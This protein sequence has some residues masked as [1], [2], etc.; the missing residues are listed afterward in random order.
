[1]KD[2]SKVLL[3]V[4]D[5]KKC[6]ELSDILKDDFLLATATDAVSGIRAIGAS[7]EKVELIIVDLSGVPNGNNDFV[8]RCMDCRTL[9]KI[10]IIVSFDFDAS[11]EMV[12]SA[13]NSGAWDVIRRPYSGELIRFRVNNIIAAN[14]MSVYR[15]IK[16]R[17]NYDTMTGVYNRTKFF[18]ET[19]KVIDS[20]PDMTFAFIRFDIHKFQLIN[21]FYGVAEG[22]KLIKF[23]ADD[24]GKDMAG[25]QHEYGKDG[26]RV[27]CYGHIEVDVFCCCVPFESREKIL[28]YFKSV[29]TR[30]ENYGL[31]FVILPVFGV[32]IIEDRSLTINEMYDRAN[33]ASKKC[34]GNY[35]ENYAFYDDEMGRTIVDEQMIVNEMS[36]ALEK[37]QFALYLQPK[38]EIKHNTLVGAEVLVRWIHP[39][40]GMISPGV[41]IPIFERNGFI[42]QLDN[43]VWEHT[44]MMLRRWLDE[45]KK[46]D[47]VSVNM[48]RISL[49]NPKLVEIICNL[50]KK[51]DV[52]PALMQLELTESA[53]TANPVVIKETMKSLQEHG[54][55]VLMDDF[56]SGYSSLNALKD[57]SLDVIKMDMRFL[58]KTEYPER[59]KCIMA[60]VVRMA[61]WLKMSV[62]AEGVETKDQLDF[63]KSIGCEYIQ[64]FYFAKPMSVEDYE[65]CA[66][67]QLPH[68]NDNVI[69]NKISDANT[70]YAYNE[71]MD[72]LF[73]NIFQPVAVYEYC[74]GNIEVIRVNS[75]Y[76]ESFGYN[77]L[78]VTVT[79][80]WFNNTVA[81]E[82]RGTIVSAFERTANTRDSASCEYLR[83][84]ED[85]TA[86][87]VHVD[88]KY[89]G[90]VE[91]RHII[92]A[93][94][95]DITVQKKIYA[96]LLEYRNL[97]FPEDKANKFILIVED[98]EVNRKILS[99]LFADKYTVYEAAD[100]KEALSVMRNKKIDLILL[101]VEMPVMN[102]VEFLKFKQEDERYN[103]IPVIVISSDGQSKQQRELMEMGCSDYIVKPFVPEVVMARVANVFTSSKAD[104]MRRDKLTGLYDR[105][106]AG[107][108][109]QTMLGGNN[110]SRALLLVD[111]DNFEQINRE[112][113]RIAGDKAIKEF[114]G[115]LNKYFRKC[116]IVARYDGD[117]FV[118]FVSNIPTKAE[119]V[120]RCE[121]LIK[122]L[123]VVT[124]DGVKLECSIGI[125]YSNVNT[126]FSE[127]MEKADRALYIAK[128]RGK[129]QCILYD[130]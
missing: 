17:E 128:N 79:D 117:E 68:Y 101:D 11:D 122:T 112:Y 54:F 50:V 53:F 46:P 78:N 83:C 64:G 114:A 26:K 40:K 45:G 121:N 90:S 127:M 124:E 27:T 91:D 47:P 84:F 100:G 13:I 59:S 74:R 70:I 18:S 75:A 6:N 113:G 97:V 119:I 10:P 126:T 49:Y 9:H 104:V 106:T 43:Y 118:V 93:I 105:N 94:L 30:L 8:A 15:E 34:K 55:T 80:G 61:K 33:M 107:G 82:F 42:M 57:M 44:C 28:G 102:G 81:E 96:E 14:E 25:A 110:A 60:S 130:E 103:D 109:I 31:D 20:N 56:G 36:T 24:M 71:Q 48:S 86:K 69:G 4:D 76:Y 29:R 65:K 108:I 77:D 115:E 39:D 23:I 58:S 99:G 62:T 21:Q 52:P 2:K 89:V 125:S 123:D 32:Y 111:I 120:R 92:F 19:R 3:V 85:G 95:M 7:K 98:E 66:F 129:N 38:Y 51:Y 63:L 1:M 67:Q 88:L 12:N 116:D 73:S 72:A 22:D 35:I 37:E 41:F 87:W 5:E 16:Y